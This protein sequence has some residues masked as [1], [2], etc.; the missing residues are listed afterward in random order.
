M[1]EI[2]RW[3]EK[4]KRQNLKYLIKKQTYDFQQYETI[5]YFDESIYASKNNIDE[6][7]IDQSN[8]L[9]NI[10]EFY[11]KSR[12]RTLETKNKKKDTYESA[13]TL[14]EGRELTVN[15]FKSVI[16]P[17]KVTIGEGSKILTPQQMLQRLAIALAQVKPGNTFENLLNEIGQIINSLYR[18]KEIT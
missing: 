5:R 10:V 18:A 16:F 1:Y 12:P 8:L 3:E 2:K 6:V 7:E 13:Y 14:Y 11:N 9:K 4:I 15:A 17:K